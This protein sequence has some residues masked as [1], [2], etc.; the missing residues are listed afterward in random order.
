MN[1][2]FKCMVQSPRFK[3][4]REHMNRSFHRRPQQGIPPSL[5]EHS[6]HTEGHMSPCVEEKSPTGTTP[7][8][9]G[10]S[11]DT[12]DGSQPVHYCFT[13]HGPGGL[14]LKEE[15]EGG[16]DLIPTAHPCFCP[17]GKDQKVLGNNY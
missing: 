8:K 17:P 16:G 4:R 15:W 1:E 10:R 5:E 14:E 6:S 13:K 12:G 3:E 9:Q 2:V 7:K 11:L